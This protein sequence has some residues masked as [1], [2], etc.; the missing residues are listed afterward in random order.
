MLYNIH[1]TTAAVTFVAM[2][3]FFRSPDRL[4]REVNNFSNVYS[5][6]DGHVLDIISTPD[7]ERISIFLSVFDVHVQYS[8]INGT[9]VKQEYIKGQF[10]P[11]YLTEK[12]KYNERLLTHIR[13]SDGKIVTVMQIAG[14]IANRIE[15]FVRPG[16]V[17][18]TGCRLGIIKFG[19]RVDIIVPKG[20]KT[21]MRIGDYVTAGDTV[22][23]TIE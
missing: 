1:P 18:S 6:A 3:L 20:A 15:S 5:P 8:P 4:P 10:H 21:H 19:S 9:V 16:D 11:A 12:S 22:L 2:V 13:R 14:Q 7:A 17:V 23:M